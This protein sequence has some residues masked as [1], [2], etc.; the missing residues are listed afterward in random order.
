MTW[1]LSALLLPALLLPAASPAADCLDRPLSGACEAACLEQVADFL[2]AHDRQRDL[3]LAADE[4]L[5]T[6]LADGS[7]APADVPAALRAPLRQLARALALG[8][9]ALRGDDLSPNQQA[10]LDRTTDSSFLPATTTWLH[11][12][13][14][15]EL[16]AGEREEAFRLVDRVLQR[17]PDDLQALTLRGLLRSRG[18]GPE[19]DRQRLALADLQRVIHVERDNARALTALAAVHL[20][21]GQRAR[22]S[23]RLNQAVEADP[24][25]ARARRLRARLALARQDWDLAE[26]DAR[27][28]VTLAKGPAWFEA[29]RTLC[30]VQLA[31]GRWEEAN[32]LATEL[33][34]IDRNDAWAWFARSVSAEEL[35]LNAEAS[36]AAARWQRSPDEQ[37]RQELAEILPDDLRA[38]MDRLAKR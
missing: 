30:L 33:A 26:A 16:A 21:L 22:A 20:E 14:L 24:D 17:R 29:N 4:A 25:D 7:L 11:L 1:I 5:L 36:M 31:R 12:T 6:G 35:G 13:A 27:H 32:D 8:D 18:A 9:R 19:E 28:V 2:L 3:L 34:L 38:R 37:G 23:V 15:A 10:E